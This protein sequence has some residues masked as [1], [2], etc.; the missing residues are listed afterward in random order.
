[1]P[2]GAGHTGEIGKG[3]ES[4]IHFSG[5]ATIFVAANFFNEIGGQLSGIDKFEERE[6]RVEARRD[7]IGMNFF[8]TFED[9]EGRL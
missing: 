7:D 8:A 1:V 5:R 2:P 6:I 9:D 3:V 4:E